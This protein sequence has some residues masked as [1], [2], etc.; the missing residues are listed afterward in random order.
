MKHQLQSLGI[1]L[2]LTSPVFAGTMGPVGTAPDW[3]YV[4]AFSVGPVWENAGKSQTFSLT[5]DIEKAY[6]A[7]NKSNVVTDYEIFLG[8]QKE[9]PKAFQGQ[10][11]LEV[12][13]TDN[14]TPSGIIW[15]DADPQFDNYSYGYQI[16]HT[17]LALKGKLLKDLGYWVMPWVSASVGVGFNRA[18][19][20]QNTP[21]I[22]EAVVMP[23]FT[24]NTTTSFT[25]TVGAGIQ[26]AL[27]QQWQVGVGYEFADWGKSHLGSAAGQTVNS[28]L[29]L[30]HLYTNGFL[31]NVTYIA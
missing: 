10:L 8:V 3:N 5:P 2:L 19:N 20:F 24:D 18:Q 25:Y 4:A 31:F 30:N 27:T 14:A 29:G 26:K 13:V 21:L 16:Q 7:D 28:G 6:V 12:A 17:H 23:N 22:P 9:L 15:D 11:G 1:T